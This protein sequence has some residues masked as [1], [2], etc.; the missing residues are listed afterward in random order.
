MATDFSKYLAFN[1]ELVETGIIALDTVTGGGFTKGDMVEFS[2]LPG[3]GKS[4]LLL[5]VVKNLIARGKKCAYL[6]FERAVKQSLLVGMGM[7]KMRSTKV[8]D[9]FLFLTPIT[10]KDADE[11]MQELLNPKE[12]YDFIVIDSATA[13]QAPS[14]V[15][16]DFMDAVKQ[17]GVKARIMSIALERWKSQLREVGTCLCLL[18]QMRTDIDMSFGG[19]TTEDSAGGFALKFYPDLRLRLKEGP[20]MKRKE[21][22]PRGEV[23]IVYGNMAHLWAEKN[24]QERPFI[25]VSVPILY[26]LGVA[27]TLTMKDL[28][29]S[30]GWIEVGNAGNFKI[31][32]GAKEEAVRGTDNLIEWIK[33]NHAEIKQAL[34]DKGLLKLTGTPQE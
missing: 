6:D 34:K 16:M 25:K 18:N 8:G 9:P 30:A 10:F 15:D 22:T 21:L 33:K 13:I 24:K 11:I 7:E 19:K 3:V 26:G 27:N 1:T 2:S 28:M 32:F 5:N 23:D 14:M 20:Q 12:P 4:T 29:V 31:K 17:I